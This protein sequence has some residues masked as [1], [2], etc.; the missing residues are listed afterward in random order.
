MFALAVVVVAILRGSTTK[1]SQTKNSQT[2]KYRVIHNSLTHLTKS[3]HLNGQKDCNVRLTVGKINFQ[4]FF[5][6]S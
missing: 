2:V 5:Q 3:V 1:L 6:T 4:S